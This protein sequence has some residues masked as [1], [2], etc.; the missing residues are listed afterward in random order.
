MTI[1]VIFMFIQIVSIVRNMRAASKSKMLII[2]LIMK[3]PCLHVGL[4]IT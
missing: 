2:M 4:I 1:L 3:Y